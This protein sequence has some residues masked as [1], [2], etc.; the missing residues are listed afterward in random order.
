MNRNIIALLCLLTALFTGCGK[1]E[2]PA[3][4]DN[5]PVHVPTNFGSATF[6]SVTDMEGNTYKTIVI[7]EETWMA[8][9]LR[10]TKFQNG[11]P[12]ENIN[13]GTPWMASESPAY[14]NYNGDADRISLYGHL[15]NSYVREDE[16]NVCPSGWHVPS[17]TEWRAID[18]VLGDD[19][20][21]KMKEEGTAHWI[22]KN[23]STNES[24]F[25]GMPGG[26]IHNGALTDLGTDGYWWSTSGGN[27]FYL[28]NTMSE[29]R[30]KNT[31]AKIS[32]LAI[33]CVQD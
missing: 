11:D 31:A 6:G 10:V 23:E 21:N 30:S 17:A 1:D 32:G 24:G 8:E 33:R 12:I 7:G 14:Y 13:S 20:G 16:R 15:Y 27:F 22:T 9:N 4:Q 26:S 29:V 3:P 28:T 2:E 18:D 25:T 19:A 5:K